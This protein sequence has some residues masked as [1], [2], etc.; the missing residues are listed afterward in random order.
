MRVFG[1]AFG[2]SCHTHTHTQSDQCVPV[3]VGLCSLST[4]DGRVVSLGALSHLHARSGRQKVIT[5]K[6]WVNTEW[7]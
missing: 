1:G 6:V 5:L 7:A 4:D 3:C 2:R